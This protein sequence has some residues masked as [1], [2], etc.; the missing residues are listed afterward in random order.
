MPWPRPRSRVRGCQRRRPGHR[1]PSRLGRYDQEKGP[2]GSKTE[3]ESR[4]RKRPWNWQRTRGFMQVPACS[5]SPASSPMLRMVYRLEMPPRGQHPTS[6]TGPDVTACWRRNLGEE[7]E[8]LSG[9]DL[10][11][12]NYPEAKELARPCRRQYHAGAC[13]HKQAGFVSLLCILVNTS[14][15]LR[16]GELP[17]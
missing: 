14:P 17:H 9:H 15:A 2:L 8:D 1:T 6:P 10:D 5:D 11:K 16:C 7:L 13:C 12:G 3:P 4:A